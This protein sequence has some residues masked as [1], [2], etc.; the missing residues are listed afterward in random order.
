MPLPPLDFPT[1]GI[2]RDEAAADA[3][4]ERD[5]IMRGAASK[6]NAPVPVSRTTT[7]ADIY[8]VLPDGY[9]VQYLRAT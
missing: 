3:Y 8:V 5:L 7:D 4:M 2:G 6:A 1:F 9:R